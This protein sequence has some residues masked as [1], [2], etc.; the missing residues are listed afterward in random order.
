M[1]MVHLNRRKLLLFGLCGSAASLVGCGGSERDTSSLTAA[2]T[3]SSGPALTPAPAPT[4]SSASPTVWNPSP[5]LAFSSGS[6]VALDLSITLPTGVRRGGIFSLAA[7][8]VALPQGVTLSSAGMLSLA[9]PSPGITNGIV[10]AYAE[11]S[12]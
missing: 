1:T 9:N 2:P 11:P 6:T 7:G 12:A 4:P 10:F 5:W 3:P 8:S